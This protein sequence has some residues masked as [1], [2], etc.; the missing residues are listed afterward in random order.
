MDPYEIIKDGATN[1]ADIQRLRKAFD[2]A[3]KK[4]EDRVGDKTY[5]RERLARLIV[6]FGNHRTAI[7]AEELARLAARTYDARIDQD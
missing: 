7:D 5:V 2:L 1:G 4:L 3:W 6:Q